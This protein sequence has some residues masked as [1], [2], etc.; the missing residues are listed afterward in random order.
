MAG[1]GAGSVSNGVMTASAIAGPPGRKS[2]QGHSGKNKQAR[3]GLG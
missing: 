3:E 2:A 1:E